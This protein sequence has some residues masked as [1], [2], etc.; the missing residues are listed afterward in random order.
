MVCSVGD[1]L[2]ARGPTGVN[3]EIGGGPGGVHGL[4]G[5]VFAGV[6]NPNSSAAG[7]GGAESGSWRDWPWRIASGVVGPQDASVEAVEASVGVLGILVNP[8]IN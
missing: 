7:V 4:A 8:S 5:G 2:Q 3:G 1:T 6:P